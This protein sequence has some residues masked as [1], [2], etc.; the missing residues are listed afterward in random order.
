MITGYV[1][2]KCSNIYKEYDFKITPCDTCGRE[3]HPHVTVKP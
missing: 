1:F 3:F 2:C